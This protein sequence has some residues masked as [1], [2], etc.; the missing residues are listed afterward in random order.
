MIRSVNPCMSSSLIMIYYSLF[1][2]TLSWCFIFWGQ[3][4]NTK[5]LFMLQKRFVC[6]MAGH[7]NRS[8]C[9]KCFRQ[10][11]ILPLELFYYKL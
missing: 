9:R 10:L 1:H 7:G 3:A 11:G 6:L 4:A 5:K 8:S 2:S